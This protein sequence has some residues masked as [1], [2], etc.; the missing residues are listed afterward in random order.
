MGRGFQVVQVFAADSKAACRVPKESRT[1][2]QVAGKLIRCLPGYQ[3]DLA[4]QAVRRPQTFPILRPTQDG[5]E[6]GGA[7]PASLAGRVDE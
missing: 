7:G 4:A 3:T 5:P 6:K 2:G 1:W